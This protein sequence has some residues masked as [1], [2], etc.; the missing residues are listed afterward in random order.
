MNERYITLHRC[1]G[2]EVTRIE[3]ATPLG[4]CIWYA[5]ESADGGLVRQT[6]KIERAY[7]C[8]CPLAQTDE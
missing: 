6:G 8:G 4:V 7:V 2:G 3:K 1:E 5:Y